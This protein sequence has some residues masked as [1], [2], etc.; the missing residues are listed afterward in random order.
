LILFDKQKGQKPM[1]IS[2]AFILWAYVTFILLGGANDLIQRDKKV[3]KVREGWDK[4]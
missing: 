4:R 3:K 2:A 1:L